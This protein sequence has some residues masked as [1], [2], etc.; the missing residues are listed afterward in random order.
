MRWEEALAR[1]P[2]LLPLAWVLAERGSCD[3]VVVADALGVPVRLAKSLVY[4][5]RR[6]GLCVEPVGVRV[7]RSGREFAGEGRAFYFYAKIRGRRVSGA[8]LSKSGV[9]GERAGRLL[10]RALAL[11]GLS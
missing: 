5:A 9:G 6:L 7:V 2:W 4:H 8:A 1:R 3:H 10:E 11:L